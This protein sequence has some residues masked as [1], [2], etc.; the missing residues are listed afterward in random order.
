M[1]KKR[2]LITGGLGYIGSH[3]VVAL[4]AQGYEP[5]IV[6]NLSNSS[7]KVV[8]RLQQLTK[9]PIIYEFCDVRKTKTAESIIKNYKPDAIIHFAA[10]KAVSESLR[11]PIEYYSNNVAGTISILRAM[12]AQNV[13]RIVFSSSATVYGDISKPANE[14]MQP[15]NTTNPYGTTKVHCERILRDVS[16]AYP[17]WQ[18]TTLRY[19]NPIGAHKSGL[20][21]EDPIGIPNN[22]MPHITQVASGKLKELNVYGDDYDT[23]DGTCIRDYIHVTDLADG[24]VAALKGSGKGL[25]VY[26][27]GMGKGSSVREVIETFEQSTG[28]KIP[29]KIVGRRKGDLPNVTADP[30][31]AFKELGWKT[32]FTLEDMCRD[33]WNWQSQNPNGY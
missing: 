7:N 28:Q 15:G 13:R 4:C 30:S 26:N 1:S 31:K 9:Q 6:D 29:Y 18:I 27:L 12:K 17:E 21:G 10:L 23:P 5:I 19:F 32:R 2:I 3:T 20:I 8:K 14:D 22:L 16:I 33:A 24:H 25:S 11:K